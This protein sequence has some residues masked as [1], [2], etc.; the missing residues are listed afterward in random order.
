MKTRSKR[1]VSTLN[2]LGLIIYQLVNENNFKQATIMKTKES[3][4]NTYEQ[5]SASVK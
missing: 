2:W 4:V 3:S 1:V 5:N